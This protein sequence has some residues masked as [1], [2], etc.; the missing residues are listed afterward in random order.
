MKE[1]RKKYLYVAYNSYAFN[2]IG[3]M[4]IGMSWIADWMPVSWRIEYCLIDTNTLIKWSPQVNWLSENV[5]IIICYVCCLMCIASCAGFRDI[6]ECVCVLHVHVRIYRQSS[7]SS[8][9]C[10]SGKMVCQCTRVRRTVAHAFSVQRNIEMI[11]Q[12]KTIVYSKVFNC[13]S[14]KAFSV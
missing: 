9:R 13:V 4:R 7:S 11:E 3:L 12:V 1:K 2:V 8:I 10:D 14:E 5:A 6:G